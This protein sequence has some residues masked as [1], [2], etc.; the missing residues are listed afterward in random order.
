MSSGL[1]SCLHN[2]RGQFSMRLIRVPIGQGTSAPKHCHTIRPYQAASAQV[3]YDHHQLL[4]IPLANTS[5]YKLMAGLAYEWS[6]ATAGHMDTRDPSESRPLHPLNNLT[7]LSD[8]LRKLL[9][10][11]PAPSA[12]STSLSTY[13]YAYKLELRPCLLPPHFLLR[14]PL[15]VCSPLFFSNML[16]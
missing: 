13:F 8:R 7:R 10:F 16:S 14:S 5:V 1:S 3:H 11:L 9:A 2:I 15:P 12:P 6:Y 4:T